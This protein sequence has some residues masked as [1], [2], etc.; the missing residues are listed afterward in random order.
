MFPLIQ[1]LPIMVKRELHDISYIIVPFIICTLCILLYYLRY[2]ISM[3]KQ[4]ARNSR[5][6]DLSLS[7]HNRNI[8]LKFKVL[9]A[10]FIILLLF[11]ELL[12]NIVRAVV[13]YIPSS[14][15]LDF[16]NLTE[17]C[18]IYNN[19][20]LMSELH[21]YT[22]LINSSAILIINIQ[23]CILPIMVLL[24]SVLI[25]KFLD[26]PYSKRLRICFGLIL[27]RFFVC[28][29]FFS[30]FQTQ[31]LCY[32]LY[33]CLCVIDYFM[34][35]YY[36]RALH[37]VLCTRRNEARI[38]HLVD[39]QL[40]RERSLVLYQYRVTTIYT[41]C[42]ISVY[43]LTFNILRISLLIFMIGIDS[44]YFDYITAGYIPTF[45][46]SIQVQIII[47]DVFY[48]ML[49]IGVAAVYIYQ[50]LTLIAYLAVCVS[51]VLKYISN[52]KR[53]KRTQRNVTRLVEE[54]HDDLYAYRN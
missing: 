29:F 18:Q 40:F 44:C 39:P 20:A 36:A 26:R 10:N 41:I 11:M 17:S 13:L 4:I 3:G 12:I 23:L 31:V 15:L 51:I 35:L 28:F 1:E 2:R 21:P 34:Y 37:N 8:N 54:Y 24:I 43:V 42:T 9:V 53:H 38:H 16:V 27:C 19:P 46:F 22:W 5:T 52:L 7:L 6:P 45:Q 14:N 48:G 32:I 33:M 49:F 47:I 50:L 30:F 25:Q